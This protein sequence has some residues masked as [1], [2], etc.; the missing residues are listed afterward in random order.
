MTLIY[1]YRK[2]CC[3]SMNLSVTV[4]VKTNDLTDVIILCSKTYPWTS[5][6]I[7]GVT[8]HHIS[9]IFKVHSLDHS[10]RFAGTISFPS[11]VGKCW[12]ISY[13]TIVVVVFSVI[14]GCIECMRCW[15]FLPMFAVSVR[16]SVTRLKSARRVQCTPHTVCA[17]SFGAA[18]V[19]LLWPLVDFVRVLLFVRRKIN[20]CRCDLSL[21]F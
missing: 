11:A 16:L 7:K 15:L 21:T 2:R 5:R 19:K 3:D 9:N 17:G 20:L 1:R 8:T 4:N 18:F 14:L 6:C 12:L 10:V 13:W